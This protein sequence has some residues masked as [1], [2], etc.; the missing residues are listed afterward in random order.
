MTRR[1]EIINSLEKI[2]LTLQKDRN[3]DSHVLTFSAPE[4][5][6]F[7][8]S[9]T[10]EYFLK[11]PFKRRKEIRFD[12]TKELCQ[13]IEKMVSAEAKRNAKQ[14]QYENRKEQSQNKRL[15]ILESVCAENPEM[16]LKGDEIYI[17]DNRLYPRF[18]DTGEVTFRVIASGIKMDFKPSDFIRFLVD[19]SFI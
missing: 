4:N 11:Y 15:E 12:S 16:T 6:N 18:S 7:E 3:K 5:L 14:R 10:P 8:V 13:K 2:G 19:N 1:E 9:L 17:G